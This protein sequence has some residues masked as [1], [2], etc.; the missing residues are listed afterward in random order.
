MNDDYLWDK[1]GKP[2]PEVQQ[3]EEILGTLRYQPRELEIPPQIQVGRKSF[4]ARALAIA[5]AIAL[6]M[7]GLGVWMNVQQRKTPDTHKA[8]AGPI[9]EKKLNGL[10]A[11]VPVTAVPESASTTSTPRRRLGLAGNRTRPRQPRTPQLSASEL[12]EARLAKDQ[13]MLALRLA[14]SKLSLAQKKT[15]GNSVSEIHNQHKAG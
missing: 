3:L 2:D 8:A 15:Q 4:I 10:N 1:S 6:V 14:S 13:L 5:A 11:S 9:D 7:L 12:A